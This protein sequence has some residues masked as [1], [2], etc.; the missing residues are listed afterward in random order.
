MKSIF[1]LYFAF[2]NL[3]AFA[4]EHSYELNTV[5]QASTIGKAPFDFYGDNA[6]KKAALTGKPLRSFSA[7]RNGKAFTEKDLRG[8]I[9]FINFWFSTC[10]PCIAEMPDLDQLYLKLKGNKKFEFIS[11]CLD[12]LTVIHASVKKYNIPYEVSY[13]SEE[14]CHR[15]NGGLG[16]PTNM[17]VDEKGNVIAF[18]RLEKGQ[19]VPS[20]MDDLYPKILKE[21]SRLN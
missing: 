21:L 12:P 14:D 16:F 5:K 7:I 15:L 2:L 4:Q 9:V 13:L 3:S 10:A 18:D 11:F 19:P 6:A 17:I 8:K 1:L 20:V